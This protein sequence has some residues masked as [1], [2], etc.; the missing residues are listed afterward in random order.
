MKKFQ[1]GQ[2]GFTLIELMIVVAIIGI[3]ASV[4]IPAYQDYIARSK[5]A[6]ISTLASGDKQRMSEFYQIEGNW[7]TAAEVAA[8]DVILS[9]VS[10]YSGG[11]IGVDLG[12]AVGAPAYTLTYTLAN[13]NGTVNA[14][15]VVF[16]A[17][18]NGGNI[19]WACTTPV[20][21]QKWLPK[22]CTGQ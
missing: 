19:A 13:V 12:A 1:R 21:T 10:N 18:D 11:A 6:E 15:D 20:I 22:G 17:T 2:A 7:P 14:Q 16:T 4:A 3:L 9:G 8:G 5:I